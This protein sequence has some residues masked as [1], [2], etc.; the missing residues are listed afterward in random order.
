MNELRA[1]LDEIAEPRDADDPAVLATVVRVEGSAYR[2]IGARRLITRDG[3]AIGLVSGGCL[4]SDIAR[5]AWRRT[6]DGAAALIRYDSADPDGEWTFGLGCRG[7]I[8]ILLERIEGDQPAA[9]V[10]FLRVRLDRHEPAVLARVLRIDGADRRARLGSFLALGSGGELI[11]DLGSAD[12]ADEVAMAARRT[13]AGGRSGQITL[14]GPPGGVSVVLEL[15]EPPPTLIV[16]GVGP[17]ALPVVR[18][19]RELGW[20]VAVVDGRH[21][22]TPRGRFAAA[23]EVT[24]LADP[25]RVR[26]LAARPRVAAV[27]MTHNVAEDKQFLQILLGSTARYIGLLGPS[28]RADRL[29]GECG[30]LRAED[31]VRL[32]AP[33][34]LDLGAETPA[35]IALAILA[36]M[37]A[38]FA[39]RSGGSLRMRDQPIHDRLQPADT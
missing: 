3:Q 9:W 31:R 28:H 23:S 37:Q 21:Q 16:C 29:L 27:V 8:D 25:D 34:G 20:H 38:V 13:L 11:H 1:I 6:E 39:G 17:D 14:P 36:E 2:G 33:V 26:A 22:G 35:E 15:V 30:L 32:H 4:E 18:L 12:L 24:S 5:Q 7:T 19:S 10:D